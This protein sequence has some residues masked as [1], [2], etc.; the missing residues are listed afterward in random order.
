MALVLI[1]WPE[2]LSNNLLVT[3]CIFI[4]NDNLHMKNLFSSKNCFL[5]TCT[6][7]GKT[8]LVYKQLRVEKSSPL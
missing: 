2:P 6:A 5:Y 4:L 1:D 7:F 3:I 8:T